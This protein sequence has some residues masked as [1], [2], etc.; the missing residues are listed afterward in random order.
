MAELAGTAFG[1]LIIIACFREIAF[2]NDNSRM[3]WAKGGLV[4]TPF[5]L[6]GGAIGGAEAGLL[7]FS[8]SVF[9]AAI[10]GLLTLLFFAWAK[11]KADVPYERSKRKL[12]KIL[13]WIWV[14]FITSM[15]VFKLSSGLA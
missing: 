5:V 11:V 10:T 7:E 14:A 12:P 4:A 8:A 1:T 13:A 3:S 2:P 15:M 6:V 9:Q